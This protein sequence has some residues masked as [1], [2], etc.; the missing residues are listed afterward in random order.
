[1][2]PTLPGPLGPLVFLCSLALVPVATAADAAAGRAAIA[3]FD[4]AYVVRAAGI[5]AAAARGRFRIDGEGRYVYA[6][7]VRPRG[8]LALFRDDRIEERSEGR[9]TPDGPVPERYRYDHYKGDSLRSEVIEF[10]PD[11]RIHATRRGRVYDLQAPPGTLDRVAQELALMLDMARGRSEL[12]YRVFDKGKIRDYRYRQ[13]GR[14]QTEVPFGR[15]ECIRLEVERHSTKRE[16]RFCLAPA[17]GFLPLWVEHVEKGSTSRME[18][19]SFEPA[20]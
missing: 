5:T 3:P 20:G 4:A 8:L 12:R 14:E 11:G 19:E 6:R 17:L 7:T 13:T 10:R 16:T 9:W 2:H 18:L 1:M 15:Y